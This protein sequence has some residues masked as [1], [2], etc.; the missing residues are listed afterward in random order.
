MG[1]CKIRGL[2]LCKSEHLC[3]K[4]AK[5]NAKEKLQAWGKKTLRVIRLKISQEKT[6]DSVSLRKEVLSKVLKNCK[7]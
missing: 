6:W 4:K 7:E 1:Q 2:R 3:F 5:E